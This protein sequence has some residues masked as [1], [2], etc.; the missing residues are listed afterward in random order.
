MK[1]TY[2]TEIH[3]EA[4]L[5]IFFYSLSESQFVLTEILKLDI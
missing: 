4:F 1:A 2:F 5:K 3:E